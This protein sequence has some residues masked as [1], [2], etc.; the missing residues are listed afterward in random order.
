[1]RQEFC[2]NHS[3]TSQGGMCLPRYRAVLQS[4]KCPE[5]KSAQLKRV[6]SLMDEMFCQLVFKQLELKIQCESV[7]S[8]RRK[9]TLCKAKCLEETRGFTLMKSGPG[10][11]PLTALAFLLRSEQAKIRSKSLKMHSLVHWQ[12]NYFNQ[13]APRGNIMQNINVTLLFIVF[14]VIQLP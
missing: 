10:P 1:M 7:F 11:N 13:K 12:I 9:S 2:Q 14:A 4:T 3:S 6:G 5:L 8:L